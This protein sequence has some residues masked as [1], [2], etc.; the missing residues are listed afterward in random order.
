MS[1]APKSGPR[2]AQSGAQARPLRTSGN[3]HAQ[4]T[5]RVLTLFVVGAVAILVFESAE[6]FEYIGDTTESVGRL[7]VWIVLLSF[8]AGAFFNAGL[9]KR[10]GS[11]SRPNA[12]GRQL[13]WSGVFFAASVL[14]T[15]VLKLVE[16]IAYFDNVPLIGDKSEFKHFVDKA[17]MSCWSCGGMYF[18]YLLVVSLETRSLQL[19]NQLKELRQYKTRLQSIVSAAPVVITSIDKNETITF[20][21]GGALNDVGCS[22]GELLGKNYFETWESYPQLTKSAR[23]A[24]AGV[25]PT[26]VTDEI[27]GVYLETRCSPVSYDGELTGVITVCVNVTD[28][29]KALADL[30]ATNL[31]LES[32]LSELREAERKVI[33]RERLS[34][35]GEMSTGIAHDLNN[36]LSPMMVYCEMLRDGKINTDQ[37]NTVF[38][39]ILRSASQAVGIVKQLQ[40]FHASPDEN[41]G[42]GTGSVVLANVVRDAIALTRPKW[43]DEAQQRAAEISINVESTDDATVRGSSVELIQV[44]TNL[45]FNA[46]D[47]MPDGGTIGI[48]IEELDESVVLEFTDNGHGMPDDVAQRCFE[49]FFTNKADGSGLGLSVCHGIIRRLAGSIEVE[50]RA[51][52]G[53]TFRISLPASHVTSKPVE[54]NEGA[55][56]AE[57][58]RVLLIDDDE[59]VRSSTAFLLRTLG[60]EV[61]V[62]DDGASGIEMLRT[63]RYDMVITDLGMSSV[64]GYDVVQAAKDF[65]ERLPV[66]VVSGWSASEV[67]RQFRHGQ[68]PNHVLEKPITSSRIQSVLHYGTAEKN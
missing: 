63:G 41:I 32:A 13:W 23:S 30:K 48:R 62:A 55:S 44:L 5:R 37:Q 51:G 47:A 39:S 54:I 6:K 20:F 68:K 1:D 38:E 26:P 56:R 11:D 16:D 27:D 40:F 19:E 61:D 52:M 42:D 9:G 4:F 35:L 33:Q 36:T 45:I 49:P 3:T 7:L 43:H 12:N 21:D 14:I 18:V 10:T 58:I 28:R 59:S 46:V 8:V 53:T 67:T 64:S 22:A 15:L 57:S 34:A 60:V 29:V 31:R 17:I 25:E 2:D 50:S 66:V 24:F 65:N